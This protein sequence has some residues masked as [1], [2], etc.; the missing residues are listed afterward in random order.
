MA[1]VL[2]VAAYILQQIGAV[3][4][5]KLQK[6]VY[7]AQAWSHV[8]DERP[9]FEERIEAWA[10]G[11]VCPDLYARHRG[12]F[13]IREIEGGDPTRLDEDARDTIDAVLEY[14]GDKHAQWLSDL[15]HIEAPWKDARGDLP[16][17]APSCREITT[18]SMA[19]FYEALPPEA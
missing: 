9:L 13:V 4:A 8:W 3:T 12:Q 14:Y 10:N 2:D 11:P 19:A 18:D 6:L 5:W 15:T 17:G 16:P 7:Y 1:S